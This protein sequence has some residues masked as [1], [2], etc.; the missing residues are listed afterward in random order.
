MTKQL[1][2]FGMAV[3][4]TLLVL[5]ILWQ[6]RIVVVYVLISLTLAAALR[7]LF[8]RLTEQGLAMRIVWIL[9]Y[10]IV[11]GSFCLLLFLTGGVVFNEIDL[12]AHTTVSA[13]DKW[14]VPTWLEGNPFQLAL[15][16]QIPAPS[17]L[18]EAFTGDQGQFVLPAIFG[19]TQSLGE[20]FSDI[21]VIFFLTLYWSSNKTHFERLWLSLLPADQRK[22][23]RDVWHT[24]EPN[25]GAY[26]RSEVIQSLLAAVL[27]GVGY[28][29]LG[30]P[31]PA[32]LALIGGLAWLIP[33]VGAPLAILLPFMVGLLS[34]GQLSLT[35]ALYTL[36]ILMILQFL[37]EPRFFKRKWDNPILTLVILL[38]MGDAFGLAG[39][40][41]A[42]PLSAVCQILWNLLVSNR[43][44]S[45][46]AVQISDL[47]ERQAHAWETIRAMDEPP[48]ALV[49]NSMQRL[50]LLLEKAEPILQAGMPAQE[51]D[52]IPL[53]QSRPAE[54]IT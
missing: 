52:L 50:T 37:V 5:L 36:I 40:I 11:L 29:L 21:F 28:W 32:L 42:P 3:M 19:F 26:I 8:D 9:F 33:V 47:K 15:V 51:T 10:L 43:A 27:L 34:S 30:S 39:I 24:I 54:K 17:K 22:R 35:T 38:A 1:V 31:T 49:T 41:A 12:L 44:S 46:A 25:L 2:R 7:P 14:I 6:F 18:F 4:F 16:A 23:A 13:Q 48:L 20:V 53:P 45:G